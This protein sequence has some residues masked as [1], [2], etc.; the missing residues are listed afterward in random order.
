M[1]KLYH[2]KNARG[3]RVIWLLEELGVPYAVERLEFK[4]AVLRSPEHMARHPLGQLPVLETDGVRF[5][6]SGAH[7]QYLLEK[8]GQGR[9]EP[10]PGTPERAEYLQWF[11]F[12]EA[13]LAA[14][15]SHI[16]R[17]RFND[18][19]LEPSADILAYARARLTAA[20][21]VVDAALHDRPYICGDSFSAADIM[22]GYGLVMSRIIRE[23]PGELNH[24]AAYLKRLKERP[25]YAIAWA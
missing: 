8:Y 23:L 13:S 10:Q 21:G 17:Q 25:A 11:H 12:G 7:V 24:V 14:Y 22:V 3:V 20:A 6:E 9:L 1:I 2:A 5:F 18:E 19:G 15:V 4:S 16:V